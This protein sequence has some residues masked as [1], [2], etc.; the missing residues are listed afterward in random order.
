VRTIS[1]RT[2]T[3]PEAQLQ[4]PELVVRS[5]QMGVDVLKAQYEETYGEPPHAVDVMFV[6]E[7]MS[8]PEPEDFEPEAQK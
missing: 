2:V 5:I 8:P 4:Y 6:I 3:I 7:A 1:G